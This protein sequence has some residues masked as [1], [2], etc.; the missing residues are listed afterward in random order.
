MVFYTKY[1]APLFEG[2]FNDGIQEEG[3]DT[4]Q[5]GYLTIEQQVSMMMISGARL[6]DMRRMHDNMPFDFPDGVDDGRDVDPT[7]LG[8]NYDLA[9]M[10]RDIEIVNQNMAASAKAKMDSE[11]KAEEVT[12]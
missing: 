11:T 4:Q 12:E 2:K 5:R 1:N 10:S 9:D 6:E 3:Y 8:S 7:Q